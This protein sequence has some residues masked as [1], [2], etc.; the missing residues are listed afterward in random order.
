[1]LRQDAI[2]YVSKNIPPIQAKNNDQNDKPLEWP[3]TILF[4]D[5]GSVQHDN[6]IDPI[7]P[8]VSIII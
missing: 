6:I 3:C 2:I 8:I 4:I 1:M 5:C 7:K